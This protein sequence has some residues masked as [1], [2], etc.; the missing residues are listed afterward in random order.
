MLVWWNVLEGCFFRSVCV[1]GRIRIELVGCFEMMEVV[2]GDVVIKMLVFGIDWLSWGF[3]FIYFDVNDLMVGC[4]WG[5]MYFVCVYVV[6]WS[7]GCKR[8]CW[9]GG[10]RLVMLVVLCII[11][12]V[13]WFRGLKSVVKYW[14]CWW[15]DGW[16]VCV[17]C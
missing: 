7:D 5:R 1:C 2:L 11:V 8:D 13:G 9:L 4:C 16:R 3:L 14:W 15:L 6:W 17:G 12:Y 10:C